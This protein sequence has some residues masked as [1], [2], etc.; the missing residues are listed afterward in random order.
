MMG[1]WIQRARRKCMVALRCAMVLMFV[2]SLAACDASTDKEEANR[3][4]ARHDIG[5][6]YEILTE[7]CRANKGEPAGKADLVAFDAK[8]PAA[9]EYY[10]GGYRDIKWAVLAR[11]WDK[12][13]MLADKKGN[14][15]VLE[16]T[17]SL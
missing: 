2:L 9:V 11:P 17:P 10:P 8:W 15:F 6:A 4:L 5:L 14:A 3:A 7:Y 1:V 13:V 12:K 16:E